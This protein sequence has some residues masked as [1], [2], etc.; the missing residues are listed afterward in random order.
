MAIF[1]ISLIIT[2]YVPRLFDGRFVML[3]IFSGGVGLILFFILMLEKK[4]ENLERMRQELVEQE[5]IEESNE[6]Q[7]L[8]VDSDKTV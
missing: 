6:Q 2:L 1:T 5:E 3:P 4:R 7:N 8:A